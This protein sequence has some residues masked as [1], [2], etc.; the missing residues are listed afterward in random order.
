MVG[1]DKF[2]KA[3]GLVRSWV[4][5]TVPDYRKKKSSYMASKPKKTTP[6]PKKRI[7]KRKKTKK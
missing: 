3:I 4:D 5:G 6:K 2:M 1:L 7:Y